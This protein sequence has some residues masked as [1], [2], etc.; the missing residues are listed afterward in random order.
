MWSEEFA[1]T[2]PKTSHYMTQQEPVSLHAPVEQQPASH[3]QAPPELQA[4]PSSSQVHSTQVQLVQ[5]VQGEADERLWA[6]L[7]AAAANG[8][9][10]SRARQEIKRRFIRIL[11]RKIHKRSNVQTQNLLPHALVN[12][13]I[14][15][16]LPEDADEPP[17]AGRSRRSSACESQNW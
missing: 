6:V 5:Q 4:H 9:A 12:S 13:S 16:G 17:E 10:T 11:Q 1:K 8:A 15:T 14:R 3:R 7:N 2:L